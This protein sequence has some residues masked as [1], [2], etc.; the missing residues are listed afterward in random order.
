MENKQKVFLSK[1]LKYG[2]AVSYKILF[3]LFF[4]GLAIASYAIYDE[5]IKTPVVA[6]SEEY[7][8]EDKNCSVVGINLHGTLLTY[9]PPKN[10]NDSFADT[11]LSA[12]EEISY[13]I[14]QA[15]EDEEIKAI[16]LEVDSPG[17]YPVAGE[18]IAEALKRS[19]KPTVAVIR[20]SGLSAAYWAVSGAQHIFASKNS[21]VGSI[22]VTSS[23]LDN[24]AKNKKEGNDY[25]QLSAGKYKDA[26]NPDKPLTEEEKQLFIRDINIV[27]RN[28]IANIS[29]NRSIALTEV[30]RIADG[31]SVLGEQ[32]KALK[33]IDEI[34]GMQEAEAYL[35]NKIGEK[36]EICWY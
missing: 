35:E 28:F 26:G 8:N 12:S 4:M 34:G 11:D 31:S 2:K 17:G 6:T 20:Q 30:Q 9:I 10:E 5:F 13:L 24:V 19:K 14:R 32:A 25:V 22:G 27:H 33:L 15:N 1:I 3:A 36:P 21:D 16:L 29:S 23:Y 7:S 18:E